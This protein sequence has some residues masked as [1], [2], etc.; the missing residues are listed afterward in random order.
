M[1]ERQAHQ[2]IRNVVDLQVRER[3]QLIRMAQKRPND[4]EREFAPGVIER[5]MPRMSGREKLFTVLLCLCSAGVVVTGIIYAA[6][7]LAAL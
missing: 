2:T 6:H 3:A 4:L 1:N 7:L 5:H